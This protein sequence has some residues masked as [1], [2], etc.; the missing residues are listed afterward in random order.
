MWLLQ[1]L[2]HSVTCPSPGTVL[3]L[4]TRLPVVG[5]LLD[6]VFAGS[7]AVC[8]ELRAVLLGDPEPVD[9]CRGCDTLLPEGCLL[10]SG[11]PRVPGVLLKL[12]C[13]SDLV[14]AMTRSS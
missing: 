2:T 14:T 1:E 13:C 6:T 8:A 9:K 4:H 7:R 5:R 3:L 10:L 12:S 11:E